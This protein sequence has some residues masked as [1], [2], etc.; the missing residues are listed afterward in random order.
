MRAKVDRLSH[1]ERREVV[2]AI[3]E[4]AFATPR[5]Y[6]LLALATAIAAGGLL[7]NSAAVIIGAMIVAPLMGPILGLSLGMV[8]G[9]RILERGALLAEATGI[10]L[11]VGLGYLAGL[12]PLNLGV[13]AEMLARTA[14]T[15]YDLGIAFASG[16]AG[17]YVS[18]KRKVNSAIAGV[19]ISVALVPPLVTCGLLLAMGRRREATGAFLLF[20]ANFVCIQLASALVFGLYG[21][22]RLTR[23]RSGGALPLV[24]RFLPA[25]AA[26][27]LMA[28]AMTGTLVG[29]VRDHDQEA[30]VRRVLSEEIARRSG[31]RLD[32]VLRREETGDRLDVVASALTPQVF[33]PSQV[34]EV[35]AAL[36]AALGRKVRLV[37]RS[38]V[39]QD[40]DAR[41][42]VYLTDR[43]RDQSKRAQTDADYLARATDA[44]KTG[45]ERIDG[46]QLDGL[47]RRDAAGFPVLVALVRSPLPL[48]PAEVSHLEDAL[49]AALATDL[50]LIVRNVATRDAD[51]HGYL[52]EAK[53]EE[54]PTPDPAAER[55]R[56][57]V[58]E[59]LRRRMARQPARALGELRLSALDAQAV[60]TATQPVRPEEVAAIQSDLRR[61]VDP[62]L[63]L[64]IRTVLQ[65][66]ASADDWL[67]EPN[68]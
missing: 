47:D 56:E 44:L 37:L 30:A 42:R 13:S 53:P 36:R 9:R 15:A 63:R 49:R 1:P 25:L 12:I 5:F 68:P 43:E 55:L 17:A 54:S 65:S 14:P 11:A 66:E 21:F 48:G 33:A 20:G 67:A 39:S 62:G 23:G 3:F 7:S 29:L 35:E 4:G 60:V 41:G 58:R 8:T 34:A 61:F 40:V 32:A 19:A 50:R 52:Y 57:R 27:A 31:G 28:W 22:V 18:V 51:R 6:V 16:L 45:L 38:L 2:S 46:A 24:L 64:T 59:V 26:L 10:A